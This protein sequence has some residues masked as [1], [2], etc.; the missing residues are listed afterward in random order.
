MAEIRTVT[1]L[2]Y[3]RDE[4]VGS[5][6]KYERLLEQARADLAHQA[7]PTFGF[8]PRAEIATKQPASRQCPGY[9][10]QPPIGCCPNSKAS[11]LI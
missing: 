4:I 6:A 10:P 5:I 8:M 9:G 11:V 7:H 2:R 1:T 3:K